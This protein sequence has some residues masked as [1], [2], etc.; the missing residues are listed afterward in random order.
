MC[1]KVLIVHELEC[2]TNAK[3]DF[4]ATVIHYLQDYTAKLLPF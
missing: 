3:L 1:F 4:E 2:I